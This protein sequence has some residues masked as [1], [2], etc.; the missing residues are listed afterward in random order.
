MSFCSVRGGGS[1]AIVVKSL[2]LKNL[3][4]SPKPK[5]QNHIPDPPPEPLSTLNPKPETPKP[6]TQNPKPYALNLQA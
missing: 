3:S 2:N 1:Q 4:R 5:A 6:K